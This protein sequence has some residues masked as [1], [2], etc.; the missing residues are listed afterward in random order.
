MKKILISEKYFLIP[1]ATWIVFA[2]VLLLSYSKADIHLYFNQ[3]NSSF[4]DIFF[5][6]FTYVGDGIFGVFI[7][8]ILFFLKKKWGYI[9]LLAWSVSG[10]IAQLIKNLIVP[11]AIRPSKFF[12]GNESL[13]YVPFVELHKLHSFPSGHTTSAFAIFMC[14]SFFV[15]NK[16]VKTL[17]FFCALLVGISRMYLSQHFLID[18]TV[19]SLL[20]IAC[21][22][23]FK[24]LL[25][26]KTIETINN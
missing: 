24:L 1:F 13:H 18:V 10:I 6:L 23:L 5:W 16:F 12:E 22:I 21:A 3:F 7:C 11:D 25:K 8:I 14:L 9:T 19:G 20:G 17:F 2:S 15:K 26:D 4:G